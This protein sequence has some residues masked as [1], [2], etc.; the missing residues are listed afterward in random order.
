[1][2]WST[3]TDRRSSTHGVQFPLDPRTRWRGQVRAAA[4]SVRKMW[5]AGMV[6]I[7]LSAK[8]L[9]WLQATEFRFSMN[10]CMPNQKQKRFCDGL[11]A[12]MESIYPRSLYYYKYISF[13]DAI[14]FIYVLTYI[15]SR[16]SKN[17]IYTTLQRIEDTS[18]I[19]FNCKFCTSFVRSYCSRCGVEKEA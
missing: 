3:S 17:I 13:Q 5:S 19:L 1:M 10:V 11:K 18:H 2:Y 16:D 12:Q 6:E 7:L 9:Q 15:N 14:R 4:G 8:M